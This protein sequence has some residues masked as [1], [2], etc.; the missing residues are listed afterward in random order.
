MAAESKE[1]LFVSDPMCSWCYGFSPVVAKIREVYG[2]E[3]VFR[4]VVG[5][6]R[7]GN[8]QKVD[9]AVKKVVLHHWEEVHKATGQPFRFDFDFPEDFVYDTE[10][11]CRAAVTVRTLRPEATFPY[12]EALHAAFYLENRDLT[13]VHILSELAEPFG[14]DS[15]TFEARYLEKGTK[16]AAFDDFSL[17]FNLGIRGFPAVALR[18]G[19]EYAVL[20]VGYQPF[21]ALKPH[22]D[23]WVKGASLQK[24]LGT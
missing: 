6:L 11:S 10:P 13:N 3:A 22:L 2:G 9:E 8:A 12:F 19:E 24:K 1:I 14:I 17:A 16:R 5:G 23:E 18:D 4:L 15:E 21:E 20:T 7:V